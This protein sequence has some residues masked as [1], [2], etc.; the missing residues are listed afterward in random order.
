MERA[1]LPRWDPKCN[2]GPL[3]SGMEQ[4]QISILS[5]RP[6]VLPAAQGKSPEPSRVSALPAR[7]WGRWIQ[8]PVECHLPG[9]VPRREVAKHWW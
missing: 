1:S 4:Q 7:G 9:S 5:V 6:S 3:T 2:P 8:V